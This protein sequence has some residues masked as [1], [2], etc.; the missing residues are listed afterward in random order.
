MTKRIGAVS[1]RRGHGARSVRRFCGRSG[2]LQDGEVLRR[3]LD[4]HHLHDGDRGADP[5]GARLHAES[6]RPVGPGDLHLDEEQGHRR[7]PRQL[8]AFD[9]ERP[10]ALRR[11]QV[12]R[13]DRRQPAG[14]REIHARG[15]EIH[16][17]QG[18]QEL[19]RHREVQGL[20]E[21]QDLRH[22][23]RQRRQ[24]A[25]PRHDQGRQ[26]RPEGFPARR[27]E[28]AGHA[29]AGRERDAHATRTWCS[30]AGRRTR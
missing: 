12:G 29:V 3:R 9:G 17:R 6:H 1:A 4:G 26:V 10:Q 13:R 5:D 25:R 2:S 20:A 8:A 23:A 30:S 7:V 18:A 19:R 15:A 14:R 11:G 22:R 24:P 28:R 16:V 27:V 21:G